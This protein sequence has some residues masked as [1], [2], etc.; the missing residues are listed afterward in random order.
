MEYDLT[1]A[2]YELLCE[3]LRRFECFWVRDPARKSKWT[4]TSLMDAWTGLG[5]KSEYSA[6]GRAGLMTPIG[7]IPPRTKGW[8]QLLSRGAAI[9]L[10]WHKLGHGCEKGE[11]SLHTL[12]PAVGNTEETI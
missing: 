8:W 5:S 7:H 11:Y 4:T 12:P 10:H 6:A 9:V 1:P 2:Q 3:A